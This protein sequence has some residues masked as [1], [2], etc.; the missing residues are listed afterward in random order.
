[1]Y[2]HIFCILPTPLHI[3]IL[4][5]ICIYI[6]EKDIQVAINKTL[7]TLMDTVIVIRLAFI[8]RLFLINIDVFLY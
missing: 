3:Y 1:M 4:I 2:I 7:D 6:G 8:C 5:Y